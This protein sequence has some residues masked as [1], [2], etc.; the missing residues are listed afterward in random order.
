MYSNILF[1]EVDSATGF[2][3]KKVSKEVQTNEKMSF[4]EQLKKEYKELVE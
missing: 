1:I 2:E 3:K 4:I